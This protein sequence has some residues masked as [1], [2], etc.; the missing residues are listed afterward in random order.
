MDTPNTQMHDIIMS[1]IYFTTTIEFHSS[2]ARCKWEIVYFL[3][4]FKS[5]RW[6]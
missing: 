1:N 4:F 5:S 6:T 2:I 3:F